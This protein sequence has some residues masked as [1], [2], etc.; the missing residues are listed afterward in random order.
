[1]HDGNRR[2]EA[3]THKGDHWRQHASSDV[4][5]N[6][7]PVHAGCVLVEL[8]LTSKGATMQDVISHATKLAAGVAEPW[9]N[10]AVDHSTT[11]QVALTAAWVAPAGIGSFVEVAARCCLDSRASLQ[12]APSLCHR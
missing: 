8:L 6:D 10:F 4:N 2:R 1:M 11:S 9:T 3:L 12:P 7:I 5:M